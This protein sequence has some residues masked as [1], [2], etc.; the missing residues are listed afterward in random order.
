MTEQGADSEQTSSAHTHT[1]K[2][3]NT[4]THTHI[5]INHMCHDSFLM[6]DIN[7]QAADSEQT[8]STQDLDSLRHW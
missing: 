4:C 6:R 2:H 3:A 5:Y 1:P 8:S 7:Q